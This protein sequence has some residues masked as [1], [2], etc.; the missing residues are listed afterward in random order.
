MV[1]FS[2]GPGFE[3]A[4]VASCLTTAAKKQAIFFCKFLLQLNLSQP[5]NSSSISH[6]TGNP[7]NHRL[8]SAQK[9]LGY[10]SSEEGKFQATPSKKI[11]AG[12]PKKSGI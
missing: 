12:F 4:V 10:F 7:E 8:K 5:A 2:D 3:Q 6:Q 1:V 9:C 11:T